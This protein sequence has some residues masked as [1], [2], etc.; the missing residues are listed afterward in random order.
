MLRTSRWVGFDKFLKLFHHSGFQNSTIITFK[1]VIMVVP[2]ILVLSLSL[3]IIILRFKKKLTVDTVSAIFF[4]P[5]ITSLVSAGII[6][7]WI[8]NPALGVVNNVLNFLGVHH[9]LRWLQ[10]P[11]TALPT[12]VIIG[13]WVRLGFD[14]IIFITGILS[15]P[16]QYYEAAEL[17]GASEFQKVTTITLPLLNPQI[18]MVSILELIFAFKV[19]DQIFVTTQGGPS[20]ATKTIMVYLLK[21]VFNNDYGAAC[22]LT[23]IIILFLFF[24]SFIQWKFFSNKVE[25]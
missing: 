5:V 14:V 13:I 17:D 22:A 18:I 15:I 2:A 7:Q 1:Y 19:F 10:D 11:L 20:G 16:P 8:F 12:L 9:S 4:L 25:Y 24:V 3:A 21:D 6:W 23:L